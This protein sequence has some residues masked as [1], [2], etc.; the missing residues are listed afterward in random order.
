MAED[1]FKPARGRGLQVKD[2]GESIPMLLGYREVREAARDWRTFSSNTPCRVP[3]PSEEAERS[4]RQLPIETDPPEHTA[5][6][7]LVLPFF[8]RPM[9]AEY[10]T[11]LDALVAEL[12]GQEGEI[13]IVRAFALPL[14]SRALTYLLGMPEEE[15]DVW[16]GWGTHV[17]RDGHDSAEKGSTLDRYLLSQIADARANPEREDFFAA[18]TQ[19]KFDSR[20]LTDAEILGFANLTF[21]GGRDTVINAVAVIV[22]H[23]AERREQLET[24]ASDP[25][26][27]NL[28]VEEF[29]RTTSPLTHIGRTCTRA[30]EVDGVK[31]GQGERISLGWAAANY[32]PA[33][34]SEPEALNL[35]RSPN[36][37]VGFG[38]GPHQCLGAPQARA[39]LRSLVR[40]L[41]AHTRAIDI[42]AAEPNV[43]T[44][45]NVDRTVGYH[46]LLARLHH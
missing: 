2:K 5:Y 27:T 19:A 40:G 31:V 44:H 37:H 35:A 36:A 11:R 22:A 21:A 18:L 24:V 20:P 38:S 1:A 28:A 25:R 30:V 15:A 41:A 9:K 6:R 46:H 39:I 29:V 17:F 14:Q 23:F 33:V 4:V 34:F 3:I 16:I 32:D 26:A 43:E 45:A 12:L 7:A 42:L 13:D 8:R 10:L